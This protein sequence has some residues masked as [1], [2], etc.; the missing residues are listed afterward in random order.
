MLP[1]REP[2]VYLCRPWTHD[3][4]RELPDIFQAVTGML[5]R[6]IFVYRASL[7]QVVQPSV[8]KRQNGDILP[9]AHGHRTVSGFLLDLHLLSLHG[10]I[11]L[12]EDSV[13]VSFIPDC[14]TELQ[15]HLQL[16]LLN[17]QIS[18]EC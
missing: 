10:S 17:P 18:S 9:N 2:T 4:E 12:L 5:H 7:H 15:P 6:H 14:P 16:Q 8:T 3:Q 13:L 1:L 11:N